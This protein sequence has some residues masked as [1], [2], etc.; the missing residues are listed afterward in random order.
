MSYKEEIKFYFSAANIIQFGS[1]HESNLY[2]DT[3]LNNVIGLCTFNVLS[4]IDLT[5][6]EIVTKYVTYFLGENFNDAIYFTYS[7]VAKTVSTI[8]IPGEYV[9]KITGGSNKYLNATGHVHIRIT[10]DGIRHVTV[11][12]TDY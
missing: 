12:L 2:S 4:I 8:T 10:Q 1:I 7:S 11:H 5:K 6:G 3:C 9:F